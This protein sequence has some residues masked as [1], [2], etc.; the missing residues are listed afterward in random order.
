MPTITLSS[1]DLTAPAA[2]LVMVTPAEATADVFKNVRRVPCVLD[3]A[4]GIM[5]EPFCPVEVWAGS[6]TLDAL[7]NESNCGR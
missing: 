1:A 5:A 6:T 2:A 7:R 4:E 3:E